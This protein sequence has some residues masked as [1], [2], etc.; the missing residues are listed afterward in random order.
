MSL[1]WGTYNLNELVLRMDLCAA[2]ARAVVSRF[3]G[4]ARIS[5]NK[6]LVY[7]A[8]HKCGFAESHNII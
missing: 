6:T 7:A 4:P 3:Y 1:H 5:D 2:I 8:R